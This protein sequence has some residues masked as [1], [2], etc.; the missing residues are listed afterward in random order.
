MLS[1]RLSIMLSQ[2]LVRS[3]INPKKSRLLRSPTPTTS[4][5]ISP[6]TLGTSNNS[7]PCATLEIFK[8]C[9]CLRW[10]TSC[11]AL[12]LS[13]LSIRSS[14]TSLPRTT[15]KMVFS[16]ESAPNS[17]GAPDTT[18]PSITLPI[19]LTLWSLP[20]LSSVSERIHLAPHC[21]RSNYG[22]ARL[23]N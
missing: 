18:P 16:Q 7:R 5:Y 17:H 2:L 1:W 22:D 13:A 3:A 8:R 23:L 4:C 9:P 21:E 6:T 15:L 14:V 11:Q 19:L 12:R 20:P 10:C